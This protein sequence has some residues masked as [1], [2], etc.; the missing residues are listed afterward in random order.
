MAFV[1][2]RK[3]CYISSVNACATSFTT[4]MRHL[5]KNPFIVA[6]S[7]QKTA[8][9]RNFAV[10]DIPPQHC[11]SNQAFGNAIEKVSFDYQRCSAMTAASSSEFRA[12]EL[13]RLAVHTTMATFTQRN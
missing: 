13:S 1:T 12:D 3:P 11:N 4:S 7:L 2:V 5:P 8:I 6:L 9:A 10:T